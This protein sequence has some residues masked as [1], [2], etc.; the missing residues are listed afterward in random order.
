[1]RHRLTYA[2]QHVSPTPYTLSAEPSV[3]ASGWC[4]QI[5]EV[6]GRVL[7]GTNEAPGPMADAHELAKAREEVQS[8]MATYQRLQEEKVQLS[9]SLYES[10]STQVCLEFL[11]NR[12][13]IMCAYFHRAFNG[14]SEGP[15]RAPCN[16]ATVL[17]AHGPIVHILVTP[18]C[19]HASWDRLCGR[20]NHVRSG[21][22]MP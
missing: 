7:Q 13:Q 14:V 11:G 21:I 22:D 12:A 20:M 6:V 10:I 17:H 2:A 15:I 16:L 3:I 8:R 9:R 4:P 5:D 19:W 18:K 1:M